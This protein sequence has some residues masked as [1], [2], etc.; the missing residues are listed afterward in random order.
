MVSLAKCELMF[1]INCIQ[2]TGATLG[3]SSEVRSM[4]KAFSRNPMALRLSAFLKTTFVWSAR[5]K[6]TTSRT[7]DPSSM[8]PHCGKKSRLAERLRKPSSRET[9]TTTD[10]LPQRRPCQETRSRLSLANSPTFPCHQRHLLMRRRQG[11]SLSFIKLRAQGGC[12]R[13]AAPFNSLGPYC[14][15]F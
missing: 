4:A 9:S 6:L 10:V 3:S 5:R 11:P 12:W 7:R 8:I 1:H 15:K 14:R 2:L 13:C